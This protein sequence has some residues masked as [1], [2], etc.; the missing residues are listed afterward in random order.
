LYILHYVKYTINPNNNHGILQ[1]VKYT[2]NPNNS[3]G[4]FYV[5]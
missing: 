4:I 3:H 2:I 1:Y 5:V